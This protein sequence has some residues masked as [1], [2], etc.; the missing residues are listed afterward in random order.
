[1][2]S[3]IDLLQK[4]IAFGPKLIE[5]WPLVLSIVDLVRQIA[6]KFAPAVEGGGLALTALSDEEAA[7]ESELVATLTA[8]DAALPVFDFSFL[9]TVFQLAKA[10]PELLLI[11]NSALDF[12]L[13]KFGKVG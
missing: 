5:V 6:E 8:G 2:K 13:T 4:L 11:L 3:Y 9:R 10:H 12:L 1:M 7:A